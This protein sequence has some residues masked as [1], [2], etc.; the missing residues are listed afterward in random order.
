[1]RNETLKMTEKHLRS[2][3]EVLSK[4]QDVEKHVI[5]NTST[6]KGRKTTLL[7]PDLVQIAI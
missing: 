6:S 7:T 1:M 5:Y 4:K 3:A 2:F